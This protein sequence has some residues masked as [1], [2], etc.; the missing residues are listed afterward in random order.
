[1]K[2]DLVTLVMPEIQDHIA[3]RAGQRFAVRIEE[4]RVGT[5]TAAQEIL[6]RSADEDV[7][8]GAAIESVVAGTAAD[9][10]LAVPPSP[11]IVSLPALP[12]NV[13][14]N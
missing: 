14:A 9:E 4:E 6:A 2:P 11:R 13:S 10:V 5:G 12:R 3:A 8:I 1:M 7:A